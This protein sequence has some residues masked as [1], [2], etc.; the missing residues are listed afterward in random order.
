MPLSISSAVL[1]SSS[2]IEA[3]MPTVS[4]RLRNSLRAMAGVIASA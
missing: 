3:K 4:D 1:M 2:V